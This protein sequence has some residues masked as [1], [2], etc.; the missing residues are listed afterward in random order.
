MSS[1]KPI[2]IIDHNEDSRIA[3]ELFNRKNVEYVQYYVNKLGGGCCG[4]AND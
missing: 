4:G 2:L 3:L 1:C